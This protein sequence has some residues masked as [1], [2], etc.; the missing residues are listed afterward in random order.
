MKTKASPAKQ[1]KKVI[2]IIFF[3]LIA[4]TSNH[5]KDNTE[6]P[7]PDCGCESAILNTIPES[8]NLVGVITYKIK[9]DTQD[10]YYNNKFWITYAEQ[11]CGNCVHHM[12]VCNEDLLPQEVINLKNTG[13]S[14]SV[15]FSGQLKNICEKIFSPADYT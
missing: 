14:L 13:G 15:K 1:I 2:T 3:L 11:N 6:E 7:T 9:L 5:C 8:T 12:V 4:L 10:N